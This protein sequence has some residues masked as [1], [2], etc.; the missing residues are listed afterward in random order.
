MII[1]IIFRFFPKKILIFILLSNSYFNSYAQF[2]IKDLIDIKSSKNL[3]IGKNNFLIKE[4]NYEIFKYSKYPSLDLNTSLPGYSRS[5]TSVLQPD[6][7]YAFRESNTANSSIS[8]TVDQIIPFTGGQFSLSGSINRLDVFGTRNQTTFSSS[9]LNFN[10]SQPLNFYNSYKWENRI[11]ETS[12][13][14]AAIELKH[15]K[16]EDIKIFIDK[17]LIFSS[18]KEKLAFK[19]ENIKRLT[20]ILNGKRKLY[21]FGRIPWEN[22]RELEIKK[23]TEIRDI[24]Y[25]EKRVALKLENLNYQFFGEKFHLRKD[26]S[27]FLKD[28][29][30]CLKPLKFYK[31]SYILNNKKIKDL[32]RIYFES[33]RKDLESRKYYTANLNLGFGYNNSSDEINNVFINPNQRQNISLAINIPILNYNE[34]EKKI[35]IERLK[36]DSQKVETEIRSRKILSE[37]EIQYLELKRALEGIKNFKERKTIFALKIKKAKKALGEGRISF[38]RYEEIEKKYNELIL[39]VIQQYSKI[40][41]AISE[42]QTL[43][44]VTILCR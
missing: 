33:K 40:Y 25:L 27:I 10:L 22:L 16:Y 29:K 42:L 24:K 37:I 11:Q 15:K 20:S 36:R 23:D 21:E 13:D 39:D 9:W 18:L 26:D 19:K 7:S 5:I 28:F 12:R 8:L 30:L 43:S 44:L 3:N 35:E 4:L 17:I 41:S 14:I 6:G 32:N 2:S 31:K 38:F 34:Q 1:S